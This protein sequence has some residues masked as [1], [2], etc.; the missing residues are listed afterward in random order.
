MDQKNGSSSFSVAG[1]LSFEEE[2][3]DDALVAQW[4]EQ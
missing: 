2:R 1:I 4:I 3:R